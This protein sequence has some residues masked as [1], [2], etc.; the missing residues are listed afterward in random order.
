MKREELA[1]LA[2][3]YVGYPTMLYRSPQ[4]GQSPEGFD[5]SGYIRYLLIQKNF[6]D[7]GEIRHVNEFMDHFGVFIHVECAGRGDLVFFSW[8]GLVPRHIGIMI[9]K[10]E[11]VHSVGR[12]GQTVSVCSLENTEIK[13]SLST[14]I[15]FRNP[16]AF[17]R[18]AVRK[19]RYLEILE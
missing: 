2:M 17:K 5:C 10:T 19:G 11:Y 1:D 6:P 18:L 15:Y 9:S 4:L 7:V 16:I 14:Q 12:D 8:D 3:T 13:S